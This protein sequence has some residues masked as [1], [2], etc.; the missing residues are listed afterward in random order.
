[1]KKNNILFVLAFVAIS[2]CLWLLLKEAKPPSNPTGLSTQP[3]QATNIPSPPHITQVTTLTN[4]P[5]G[6]I[7]PDSVDE[8]AWNKWMNYRQ[9]I[10][11]QNQPVEFYARVLDQ[12]EQPVE[13]ARLK[14]KL[15]RCDEKEFS[16]SNFPHWNPEKAVQEK[17]FYL[18]SDAN[19]WIQFTGTNGYFLNI[20]GLTKEGYL[21]SYPDGNYAGV[22]YEPENKRTPTQDI[23]MTNSWDSQKGYTF[24]L[25][26]K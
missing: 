19:G 8:Q 2:I 22:H 6:L 4:N 16:M 20:W 17:D 10:L 15:T 26:K 25:Q 23:M 7:R 21:S 12:N 5:D 24:H 1:M 18:F 13:G 9:I 14:L 3:I 11:A